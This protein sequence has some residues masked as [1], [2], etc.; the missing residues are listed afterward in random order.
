MD[1]AEFKGPI[2]FFKVHFDNLVSVFHVSQQESPRF[3]PR[4]WVG[5]PLDALVSFTT[6]NMHNRPPLVS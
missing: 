3:D 6:E 2:L 1:F 5:L 4:V